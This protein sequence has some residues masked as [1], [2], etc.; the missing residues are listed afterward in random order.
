MKMESGIG[1]ILLVVVLMLIALFAVSVFLYSRK[2]RLSAED[3]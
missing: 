3:E 2:K 1:A